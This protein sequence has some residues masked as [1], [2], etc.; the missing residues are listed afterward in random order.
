MSD[1]P[2]TW[3]WQCGLVFAVVATVSGATVMGPGV[4]WDEPV[5]RYS[6]VLVQSWL[7]NVATADD[8]AALLT[9]DA[10]RT[11]FT[12]N[13]FGHNFHPP[14]AGYLQL[15]T[16]G[17]FGHVMEDLAARRLAG[18]LLLAALAA[19]L[20]GWVGR[21]FGRPA[22]LL[23]AGCLAFMPRLMGHSH[24]VGTD[25]P[26]CAFWVFAA[27]AFRRALV[28]RAWQWAFAALWACLFLVKFSGVVLGA[29]LLLWWACAVLPR[30]EWATLKR[31]LAWSLVLA[32]PLAPVALTLLL[33]EKSLARSGIAYDLARFGMEH[34]SLG[35]LLAWPLLAY[36][37]YRWRAKLLPV[38]LELPWVAVAATPLIC[39]AL[40]PTWW[41]ETLPELANFFDLNVDRQGHL[42]AIGIF[43]LGARYTYAL[44][45]HNAFVLM[46]LTIPFGTLLLGLVGSFAAVWTYVGRRGGEGE[47]GRGGEQPNPFSRREKV[48]E[49]RTRVP[50]AR[51]AGKNPH[52]NPLPAGEGAGT[53]PRTLPLY[54]LVNALA[55]CVFRM[56][57]TPGH[58]G[59]RL[60]LP[61]FV[62]WSALA[63]V[64]GWSLA[65]SLARRGVPGRAVWPILLLLGPVWSAVDWLRSHPYEL[66]YYN[67]GL[68]RAAALGMETTYWYDAVTRPVYADLSEQ[69]AGRG[70]LAYP[71]E[72]INP[73]DILPTA[74]Q[75]GWL[76]GVRLE[77]A[78][79]DTTYVPVSLLSHGSK[80]TAL[81]RLM[82]AMPPGHAVR[83][84]G[85]RLYSVVDPPEAA[86]AT[87]LR[88][89]TV[90]F[91]NRSDWTD[92]RLNDAAF[93]DPQ[94]VARAASLA[95]ADLSDARIAALA[96]T[97]PPEVVRQLRRLLRQADGTPNPYWPFWQAALRE[98]PTAATRAADLLRRRSADI[99]RLLELRGYPPEDLFGGVFDD[100]SDPAV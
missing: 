65:R 73:L 48:A 44:P 62:F 87:L 83:H 91:E 84:Q 100:P 23:A 3:T 77:P 95:G 70:P 64:G 49:G 22:G 12:Y 16:Y 75:L 72:L 43:Y 25:M 60:F 68:H 7:H 97:E 4:T 93:A 74:V 26:L 81:T 28:S 76:T 63:G 2:V 21:G 37:V 10:I 90:D 69:Y 35:L 15:A 85:V 30:Q 32:V 8:P 13:R 51:T 56:L 58:D 98:H 57:P 55:L 88:A 41:H 1:S 50:D 5:Y 53:V 39:V 19:L 45:W 36:G 18:S 92:L 46:G 59:V 11:H 86:V 96:Q 47:I 29:P 6:Q 52:S 67:V 66:S 14:M 33:G 17:I 89:L 79:G 40:N 34:P 20:Y 24:V 54:W 42:P 61:T 82:Y 27:W 31:W 71:D 78:A 94:S 80:G 99:R 38:A 9:Q